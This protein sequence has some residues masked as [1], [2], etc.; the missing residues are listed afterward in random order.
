MNKV[1]NTML[2][3]SN[4]TAY[5]ARKEIIQKH[6]GRRIRELRKQLG[7][8]G[9]ELGEKMGLSRAQI[10][11]F[12][13]GYDSAGAS[14]IYEISVVLGVPVGT[15]LNGVDGLEYSPAEMA[16]QQAA[17]SKKPAVDETIEL[18]AAFNSISDQRTREFILLLIQELSS[19]Q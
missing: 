1:V 16:L 6:I 8:S 5:F 2:E 18:I 14:Q 19:S 17:A 13:L 11:N 15:I 3:P 7:I 9:T 4:K 12:E 10:Y